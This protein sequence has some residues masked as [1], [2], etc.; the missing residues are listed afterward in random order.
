MLLAVIPALFLRSL[1]VVVASAMSVA[2]DDNINVNI[3]DYYNMGWAINYIYALA[4]IPV[5]LGVALIGRMKPS[6]G[7]DDQKIRDG[8]QPE[9]FYS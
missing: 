4:T 8:Q 1:I 3:K 9:V 2:L 6:H 7:E 5:F